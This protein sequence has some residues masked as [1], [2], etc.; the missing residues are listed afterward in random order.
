MEKHLLAAATERV[1]QQV[2]PEHYQAFHLYALQHWPPREVARV[3]RMRIPQVYLAK[4][5]VGALLKKEIT[6]LELELK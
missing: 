4:H 5:R 3:L 6:R 2:K 1:K